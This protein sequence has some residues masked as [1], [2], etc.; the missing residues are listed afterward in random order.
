MSVGHFGMGG[1]HPFGGIFAPTVPIQFTFSV[2]PMMQFLKT[3]VLQNS[4][5]ISQRD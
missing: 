2:N 4:G 5:F 1:R 3:V